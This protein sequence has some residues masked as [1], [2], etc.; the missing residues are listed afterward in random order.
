M[1][2]EGYEQIKGTNAQR[3]TNKKNESTQIRLKAEYG[4]EKAKKILLH[5]ST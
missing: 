3:K 1:Q 2:K 4:L 5:S